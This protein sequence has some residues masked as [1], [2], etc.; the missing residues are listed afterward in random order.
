MEVL[1]KNNQ[2]YKKHFTRGKTIELDRKHPYKEYTKENTVR[3]CY[4]CN[5]AKTDE[6]FEDEFLKIAENITLAWNNRIKKLIEKGK[7]T[8]EDLIK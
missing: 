4:W 5:N 2:I 7:L 6:F 8:N 3:C 1:A